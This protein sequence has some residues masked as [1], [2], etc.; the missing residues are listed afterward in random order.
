M[1]QTEQQALGDGLVL[2]S[3]IKYELS[4]NDLRAVMNPV[5]RTLSS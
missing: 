4:F 3:I 5:L 2:S 1:G